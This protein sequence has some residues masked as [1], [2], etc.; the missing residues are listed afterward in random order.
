[1]CSGTH[2]HTHTAK[3]T[4]SFCWQH[5]TLTFALEQRKCNCILI[6]THSDIS[7]SYCGVNYTWI[8]PP[9]PLMLCPALWHINYLVS[10]RALWVYL[11]VCLH[12]HS[13]LMNLVQLLSAVPHESMHLSALHKVES[14][15]QSQPLS[16]HIYT[17]THPHTH[18]PVTVSC[19]VALPLAAAF[20]A[21]W[22]Q[23]SG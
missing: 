17:H 16:Y 8:L 14:G 6:E 12:L 11:N 20:A 21:M 2:T 4:A 1:M 23:Q 3:L 18:Q 15:V 9:C 10:P 19:K 7:A 22:C 13:H 5:A